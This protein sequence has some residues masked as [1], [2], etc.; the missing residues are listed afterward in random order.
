M[1]ICSRILT[2]TWTD[3]IERQSVW[4]GLYDRH[5]WAVWDTRAIVYFAV[6]EAQA[7]DEIKLVKAA[8]LKAYI[9]ISAEDALQSIEI[10]SEK[11]TVWIGSSDELDFEKV[12]ELGAAEKNTHFYLRALQRNG[13]IIYA[14]PVFV[15][16]VEQD[17]KK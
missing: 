11:R 12:I 16:V 5:T 7:G 15:T 2:G 3:R 10:V 4:R 9:K 14:S 8:P 1:P 13:G 17:K 6:N